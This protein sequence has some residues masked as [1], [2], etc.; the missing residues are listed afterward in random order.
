MRALVVGGN[1]FIGSHLVDRLVAEGWETVVLDVGQRRFDSNPPQ[2]RFIQ[3]DLSQDY[4]L[5][6]ALVGVDLVFH[7]AWATIHETSNRDPAA[8]IHTNLVPTIHL[9][10]ACRWAEVRRLVFISSGGTVYGPA[11][12]LPIPEDHPL[13]PVSAYGVTKLAVE[14]YLHMFHQLFGLEHVIL[15]PSVPYGPRQNP[16]GRQGAVA[17]FMH[18]V[19]QGQP[20]TVWGDGQTSR[21]YFYISDM[22]DALLA[23]AQCELGPQRAFNIGG[24]QEVT[25]DQLLAQIEAVVGRQARVEYHPPR[26]FDAPR[27]VLDTRLALQALHWQPAVPLPDGLAHTW[28]WMQSAVE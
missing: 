16:L 21:D 23:A 9:L 28:Q 17:V 5:R 15:R 18:R 10:E 1:G 3:G 14:K 24:A 19:A 22:V 7:C 25:L 8:D 11:Q 4:L 20:V 26:D 6:E 13:N 27:I 12:V 2:A